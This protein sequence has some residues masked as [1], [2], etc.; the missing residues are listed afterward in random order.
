MKLDETL[1]SVLQDFDKQTHNILNTHLEHMQRRYV[2][3]EIEKDRSNL[4]AIRSDK[5][6]FNIFSLHFNDTNL[7]LMKRYGYGNIQIIIQYSK[8]IQEGL[9]NDK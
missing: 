1:K 8:T 5:N 6:T 7:S 4:T 3:T 2:F 9:T